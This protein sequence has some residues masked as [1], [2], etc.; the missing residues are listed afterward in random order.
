MS[1]GNAQQ[2]PTISAR[3]VIGILFQEMEN[4]ARAS[5]ISR[6]ANEFQSTVA[7]EVYAGL[8]MAPA[9]REWLGGKLAKSFNELSVRIANKDWESTIAVKN[10]DLRRDKTAQ[11]RLR[12]GEMADRAVQH[13]EKLASALILN[14]TG[15]TYGACYDTKALFADDHSIGDSGTID[16]SIAVS[17]AGI[18]AEVGG[19]VTS[20]SPEEFIHCVMQG[21]KTLRTFKDDQGEPINGS[22]KSFLVMVPTGLSVAAEYSLTQTLIAPGQSNPL[23]SSRNSF[24]V[25]VNQRLTWTD[26]FVVFRTD[27]RVKPLISQIEYGPLAKALA[28]GSDHEFKEN[29]Q[30]FSVEKSGNMGYGRFDQAVLVDIDA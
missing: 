24:E 3:E 21:V 28:E 10:K 27:N 7:E 1:Q 2:L 4:A 12:L 14:G 17:L 6:I 5:W 19:T 11:L 26:K 29:E 30:L 13:E 23:L 16:N 18:P 9:M 20:P 15:T 22:A 8:G 25:V